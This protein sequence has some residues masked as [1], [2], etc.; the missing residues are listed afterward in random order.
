MTDLAEA[1]VRVYRY[2]AGRTDEEYRDGE[3]VR[4]VTLYEPSPIEWID[5]SRRR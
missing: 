5:Y 2:I 4:I 1:G 3:S